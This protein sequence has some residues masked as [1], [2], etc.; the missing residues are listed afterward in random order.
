MISRTPFILSLLTLTSFFT[1]FAQKEYCIEQRPQKA[2]LSTSSLN[3]VADVTVNKLDTSTLKGYILLTAKH[4]S[5]TANGHYYSSIQL[6]DPNHPSPPVW[7][8][9]LDENYRSYFEN[10]DLQP[11]GNFSVYV[12]SSQVKFS[13]PQAV[14]GGQDGIL[15]GYLQLNSSFEPVDFFA[16][17]G[18]NSHDYKVQPNGERLVLKEAS[19]Q[20]D[21]ST[22]N[23]QGH[24]LTNGTYLTMEQVFIYDANNNIVFKWL[25]IDHMDVS[26][27]LWDKYNSE[28]IHSE[29]YMSVQFS[30]INSINI[31]PEDGNLL[32]SLRR[33]D[34]CL[35]V[36]KKSGDI[37]WRLGGTKSDFALDDTSKFYL[38]HDFKKIS[39]GPYKGC[40]C[41]LNNG[42]KEKPTCE[43]LIYKLDEKKKTA[44]VVAR[45]AG[46]TAGKSIGQGNFEVYSDTTALVNYGNN[47]DI[48]GKSPAPTIK[49][50]KKNKELADLSLPPNT[51]V[52]RALWLKDLKFTPP[53]LSVAVNGSNY[54][55]TAGEAKVAYW[56]DADTLS[57]SPGRQSVYYKIPY[58]LGYAISKPYT[59]LPVSGANINYPKSTPP[60]EVSDNVIGTEKCVIKLRFND[61][62]FRLG[63]VHLD[64]EHVFLIAKQ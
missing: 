57:T 54:T 61:K 4:A 48:D 33:S 28:I 36:D 51:I 12:H 21:L 56:S 11:N 6:I 7:F 49:L 37:L 35:K 25:P 8:C 1:S 43:G 46:L 3:G 23:V 5:P 55:P 32:I 59:N 13:L 38:Q 31:D 50:F 63:H 47:A 22:Y 16:T 58:G 9:D 20:M 53:A 62:T 44:K 41:V 10:C 19:K 42:N 17:V 34:V 29:D 52:Y 39:S 64:T 26:E 18:I 27:M 60:V 24:Q 15:D 40:Y 30:R 14:S 2:N 45:F